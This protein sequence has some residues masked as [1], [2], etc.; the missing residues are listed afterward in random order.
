MGS[1][2]KNAKSG[3][4]CGFPYPFIATGPCRICGQPRSSRVILSLTL[5]QV[6]LE[7]RPS[8]HFPLFCPHFI[9]DAQEGTYVLWELW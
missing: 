6:L 7:S 9:L 4:S 8:V 3:L 2:G 5:F 1:M